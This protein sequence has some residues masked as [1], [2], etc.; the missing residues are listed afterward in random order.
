MRNAGG[1]R[2]TDV[3]QHV[4][5]APLE[6]VYGALIDPHALVRWLPPQGMT[7]RFDHFDA[8]TGGSYRM[9]LTYANAPAA[10]GKSD[11]ESDVVEARFLEIAPDYRVV[12]AVDFES[13]DPSYAGTMTMTWTVTEVE[14]GTRIE[15]R[16]D[17]VP[18]GISADDHVAGMTSSLANLATYLADG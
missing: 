13:D 5:E 2:R 12:Q 17:D 15:M 11:A 10:G 9:T 1:M 8:H 4:I 16:A 6:R 7:G 3:V 18:P 14:G